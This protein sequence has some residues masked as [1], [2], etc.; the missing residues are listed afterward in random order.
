MWHVYAIS[1]TL[2]CSIQSYMPLTTAVDV[3]N[4]YMHGVSGRNDVVGNGSVALTVI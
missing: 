4:P 2:N 3:S 1:A